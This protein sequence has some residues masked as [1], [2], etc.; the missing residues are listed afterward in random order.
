MIFGSKIILICLD[1]YYL[2]TMF[3]FQ[4]MILGGIKPIINKINKD[5][6]KQNFIIFLLSFFSIIL[7]SLLNIKGNN[8]NIFTYF[9][10]GI[11]EAI[12]TIVPGISGT[13][14]L[15]MIGT[16]NIVITAFANLLNYSY[17]INNIKIILPFII[18]LVLGII[19]VSKFINYL[20]KKYKT[21]TYFAIIGFSLASILLI[22]LQTLNKSYSILEIIL[23][24]FSFIIGYFIT[25]KFSE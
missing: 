9:I 23:S 8:N 25:T 14:L 16:Y 24:F 17:L 2:V 21:N 12:S 13:A 22:F 4:G 11:F 18:G 1:K 15:M 20:F 6:N 5:F 10:S 19:I 3:C 7:L